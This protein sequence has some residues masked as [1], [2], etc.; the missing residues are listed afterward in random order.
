MYR[1]FFLKTNNQI[2][3]KKSLVILLITALLASLIFNFKLIHNQ[4]ESFTAYVFNDGNTRETYETVHH[5]KEAQ[6]I[7][8][9]KGIKIGILDKYF[10]YQKHSDLYSGG[11]DFT[12]N[13]ESFENID[14][15]GYWM[16]NTLKE[17]A[18]DTEIYALNVR[19]KN[20]LETANAIKTAIDWAIENKIDI[21]TYSAEG[22]SPE[23][24]SIIDEAV[25]KAVKNNIVTTF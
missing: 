17:V 16:A 18:P 1:R 25:D 21:L 11:K 10:G 13:S 7:S 15:H 3:M 4:T 2:N 5:I 6:S 8:T 20:H 9:G 19:G 12:N 14:E 22:F 24:K 23:V